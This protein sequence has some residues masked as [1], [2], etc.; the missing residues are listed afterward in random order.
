M[1]AFAQEIEAYSR[2]YEELKG[3]VRG[4]NAE[5]LRWK[6]APDKWS[7]TEVLAHLVDHAIV[8]SFRIREIL[9]GSEARLPGFGQDAWVA[10]QRANETEAADV[11][12]AFRALVAYHVLLL[13]RLPDADWDRSAVNFKGETVTLRQVVRA[14]AVHTHNHVGQIERIKAA[15]AGGFGAGGGGSGGGGSGGLGSD[16]AGA[17]SADSS[18]P[19]SGGIGAV[20]ADS[21]SPGSGGIGAVSADSTTSG[22]GSADA[23]SSGSVGLSSGGPCSSLAAQE[24][25]A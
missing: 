12:E 4:L 3:A 11:L 22:S 20:S 19:G 16:S 6:P 21:S 13:R 25:R 7:V 8:I 17:D 5:E 14:F 2:T 9:S 23:C 18:S 24:G 15:C 1:S 10:G